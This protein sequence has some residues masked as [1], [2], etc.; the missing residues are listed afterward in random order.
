YDVTDCAV[1]LDVP[2]V[3]D[4]VAA[5]QVSAAD[6]VVTLREEVTRQVASEK[7]RHAGDENA[8]RHAPTLTR[9]SAASLGRHAEPQEGRRGSSGNQRRPDARTDDRGAPER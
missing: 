4:L 7:P 1:Y 9:C 8:S 6:H 5:V 3:I 2:W